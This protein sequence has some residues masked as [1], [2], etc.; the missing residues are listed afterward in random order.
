M[1]FA[2][3]GCMTLDSMF[4][5]PTRIEAYELGG[6]VIPAEC[7]EL[8]S[9]GS[10]EETL[11]GA[12]AHQPTDEDCSDPSGEA[13]LLLYFHGNTAHIDEY[14]HRVEDYWSY[15]YEVFIFDYRGYGLAS[16]EPSFEGVIADGA[17]AIDFVSAESGRSSDDFLWLGLSLGGFV[18][19]HNLAYRPPRRLITEDM[20][21][22]V[23]KMLEDGSSLDIPAGWVVAGDWDNLPELA[24]MNPW[25]PHLVI[26]GDQDDFVQP[27]HA[28][29]VYGASGSSAKKLW[30]VEGAN[31][32]EDAET[33]PEGY[34]AHVQ[35]WFGDEDPAAC[36]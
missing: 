1:I 16:G 23:D 19:T 35:C 8:D 10:G 33:D 21:A 20:F 17:A 18:A 4:F 25:I 14:W 6:E 13:P 31:H 3:S 22:S 32:A 26:H 11:W 9:F 24:A 36:E 2:L 30:Y 34:A 27:E 7:Q 5:N 15:G 29:L 28:E 12:W